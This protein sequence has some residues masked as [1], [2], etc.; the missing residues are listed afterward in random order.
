M[1]ARILYASSEVSAD[2]LYATGFFVPDPFL[3]LEKNGRRFVL[4]SDLEIDRARREATV[5]HVESYSAIEAACVKK[6]GSR[7]S[8]PDV[9]AAFLKKQGVRHAETSHDFPLGLAQELAARGIRV[10]PVKATFWPEREFKSASELRKI[11]QALAITEAGMTRA[12]E[13][14]RAATIRRD[15]RLVWGGSVLTSERLRAEADT[16]ILHAGGEPRNTIVAGGRQ[17]CDPHERG[18]GPLRANELIILDIFP[19]DTRTGYYGDLTRTVV[20]GKASEA[21]RKLWHTVLEGQKKA[22]RESR[23][24]ADGRAIQ[25]G[26]R[27]FFTA[28]GYPTVQKKGRWQG[29]F[30]GLGHG[31]G[32]EIHETPRF[33]A[34]TLQEGQVLTVEP[35]LYLPGVGGVRHEDV[36]V[37]GKKTPRLLT[38]LPKPLEI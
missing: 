36:V 6:S 11:R 15:G 33:G 17:A 22:L 25:D 24:G 26:V 30:H 37:I 31:L 38:H 21:Q 7:P 5:D 14:L 23:T 9:I 1:K 18:S 12:L 20:R 35:G 19:R 4:M 3:Y 29:F 34:T 32:L 16:A 8:Q 10:T 2:M 28:Q 27:E 13:V